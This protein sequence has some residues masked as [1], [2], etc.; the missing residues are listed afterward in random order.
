MPPR[1]WRNP[2]ATSPYQ[3]TTREDG[4]RDREHRVIAESALGRPLPE[5]AQVHHHDGDGRH[6]VGSN[7]VICQDL[8]YHRLLHYRQ[9]VLRAGGNPNTDRLCSMCKVPKPAAMFAIRKRGEG[10]GYHITQC[11]ECNRAARKEWGARSNY[12]VK[13]RPA[14]KPSVLCA[15]GC[16]T[17]I[18][19]V[20]K[21]NGKA[22]RFATHHRPRQTV[23]KVTGRFIP[24]PDPERGV[25][26]AAGD[27]D[28]DRRDR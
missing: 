19:A 21:W 26:G 10:A 8:S 15:C 14:E 24:A 23:D 25:P 11:S 12:T 18:P 28:G 7:L 4:T 6:N 13:P 2:G 1:G 9:R 3:T 27:H 20:N 22:Q 16:G 5:N 17:M